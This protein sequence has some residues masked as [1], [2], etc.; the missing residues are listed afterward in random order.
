MN[1][2]AF[3][4]IFK[5][6]ISGIF[7]IIDMILVAVILYQAFNFIKNTR[8]V[9][10]LRGFIIFFVLTILAGFFH[11]LV[12]E[13]I[14]S[15]LWKISLVVFVIVF[16]PEI[17]R[18]LAEVGKKRIYEMNVDE[19]NKEN[20]LK[21]LKYFSETKTGALIV[22]ERNIGLKNYIE[23]GVILNSQISQELLKTIFMQNTPLHDGAV[24]IQ[25]NIIAS[26]ASFLPLTKQDLDKSI[27][28]RHRAGLG[29]SEIS[30]AFVLM[31]SEETGN[32]SYAVNGT[33][34][35]IEKYEDLENILNKFCENNSEKGWNKFT[36]SLKNIFSLKSLKNNFNEKMISFFVA[37]I[38]WIYI[39]NIILK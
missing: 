30:D 13:W 9:Q 39:K 31:V 20:I 23:N 22:F 26:G 4:N 29:I 37:L 3:F 1:L 24:I 6:S 7:Q 19:N 5:F 28:S 16:Q 8:A 27:G 33:F 12:S 25:D 38:I 32:I 11:F 21:T 10:M 36:K 18:A 14:F 34:N 35:K 15:S 17:R 2:D